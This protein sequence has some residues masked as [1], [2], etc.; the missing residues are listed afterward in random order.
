MKTIIVTAADETF[1]PLLLELIQSLHQ[2]EQIPCDAIGL[3]NL[4]LSETTLEKVRGRITDIVEPGWDLPIDPAL[5]RSKPF[6]R[7]MSARPFLREYF[8]GFDAYLWLDCDT[9]VQEKFAL[10]W[11]FKGSRDGFM[12]L[13]P[14]IDRSYV[15]S[16][17]ILNWRKAALTG[18]YGE[19][20]TA[21]L[22]SHPY[23]NS[24]VFCLGRDALHWESWAKFFR[25]GLEVLPKR[26]SDQTALNYAI[27]K[28]D[29]PVY[30]LPAICNWC[31]HLAT[32]SVDP[33]NGR[34]CEPHIPSRPIGIIHMAANT[35][36]MRF[37][38]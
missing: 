8:S 14:E 3:L 10:E 15:Q 11:F 4:G 12:A 28:D 2:W 31:C 18:F 17:T 6:L 9:W 16:S 29:L 27:W 32:P 34:F 25:A 7:A 35:K 26:V 38:V 23:F 37:T 19:Q 1:A 5:Q 13:A 21:F 33:A 22:A 24:G 30:P 20:A 36:D